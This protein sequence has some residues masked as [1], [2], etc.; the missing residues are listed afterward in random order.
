[1]ERDVIK[2]KT[3][4]FIGRFVKNREIGDDVGLFETR[5]VD[6]MFAMQLAMFVENDLGVEL[7]DDDL[8]LANFRSINAIADFVQRKGG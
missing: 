8:D 7:A 2:Q 6:S 4:E 5:L 1:M 3:R